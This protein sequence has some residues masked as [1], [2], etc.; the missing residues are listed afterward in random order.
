MAHLRTLPGI[1]MPGYDEQ[2]SLLVL[3]I[4][5]MST[6]Y[7]I[8][9][10][11]DNLTVTTDSE[12]V[13]KVV[14]KDETKQQKE[15]KK[16]TDWERTQLIRKITVKG[17]NAGTTNLRAKMPDGRNWIEPVE[18]RVVNNADSRQAVDTATTTPEL[19]QELQKLGLQAAVLRVAEDQM[20]SNLGV[21]LHGGSGRYG[22]A[23][24]VDWCGALAHWCY[25][26]ASVAKH[27]ANPF[28][29]NVN[30]LASPQKAISWAL[31]TGKATI[32]RYQGGDPYGWD[33]EKGNRLGPKNPAGSPQTQ[34]F[35]DIDAANPVKPADICLVRDDTNWKHV[36]LVFEPPNGETFVTID[37]NQGSPSIKKVSRN[38]NE[39]LTDGK[40]YK[41][42]FLHLK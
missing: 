16:L 41:F 25:K 39:K 13:A 33:F 9:G 20:N 28:G 24:G 38:L 11:N 29:D 26:T 31:Q 1:S 3:S 27:E 22:L 23:Q 18:V 7:L 42:V 4:N 14:T 10:T 6:L 21:T 37:G 8:E 40:T 32:L 35:I 2:R 17:V 15:N 12:S 30:T 36:A 34:K 5:N 19:R